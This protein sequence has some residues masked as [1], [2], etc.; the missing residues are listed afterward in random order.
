MILIAY[1]QL[2][3]NTAGEILNISYF[4]K[5][6]FYFFVIVVMIIGIQV[7]EMLSVTVKITTFASSYAVLCAVW[8]EKK[9][10][11]NQKDKCRGKM[12]AC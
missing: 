7:L 3:A 8:L 4:L 12:S 9:E 1:G 6:F 11:K 5:K 10:R 2:N